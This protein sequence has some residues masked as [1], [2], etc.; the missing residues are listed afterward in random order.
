M[1]HNLAGGAPNW[2]V[3]VEVEGKWSN[4]LIGWTSTADHIETV[5]RQMYFP[6]KEAAIAWA[7]KSGMDYEIEEPAEVVKSRPK[8]FPGYGSNFD[9]QRLK[10][11]K[12]VGGLRSERKPSSK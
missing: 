4:P 5:T 7:E 8:R 6:T 11:G 2:R 1:T 12:P 9:V 10:G 3:A